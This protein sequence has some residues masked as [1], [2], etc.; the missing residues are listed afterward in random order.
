MDYKTQIKLIELAIIVRI[1]TTCT[2]EEDHLLC[3]GPKGIDCIVRIIL[4]GHHTSLCPLSGTLRPSARDNGVHLHQ[5]NKMGIKDTIVTGLTVCGNVDVGERCYVI[6]RM[7]QVCEQIFQIGSVVDFMIRSLL[8]YIAFIDGSS[9]YHDDH[10]FFSNIGFLMVW[11]EIGF[12][13][14]RFSNIIFSFARL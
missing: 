13:H 1:S 4:G 3:Q 11:N 7:L 14:I 10:R 12:M 9:R 8:P 5:I 2:M 6:R